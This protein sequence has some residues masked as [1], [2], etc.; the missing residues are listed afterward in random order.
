MNGVKLKVS[1]NSNE[2]V[3]MVTIVKD[4]IS[5]AGVRN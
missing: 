5:D 2:V 4:V 3:K 1:V